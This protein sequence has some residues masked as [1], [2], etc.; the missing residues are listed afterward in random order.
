MNRQKENMNTLENRI[1]H[2]LSHYDGRQSALAKRVGVSKS[3]ISQWKDGSIKNIRPENLFKLAKVTGFSAE[4]I[5]T[6]EGL[7]DQYTTERL[8]RDVE[9]IMYLMKLADTPEK[10]YNARALI[11]APESTISIEERYR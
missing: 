2:V 10:A 7:S 9:F 3:T 8:V 5:G 1:A 6:G 11:L 4:W